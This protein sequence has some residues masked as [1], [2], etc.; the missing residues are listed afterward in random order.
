MIRGRDMGFRCNQRFHAVARIGRMAE[1]AQLGAQNNKMHNAHDFNNGLEDAATRHGVFHDTRSEFERYREGRDLPAK[2]TAQSVQAYTPPE[3]PVIEPYK[4]PAHAILDLAVALAPPV[5][6]IVAVG[7][8]LWVVVAACAAAV[9]AV[10]AFISAYALPIGGGLTALVFLVLAVF[11]A[12]AGSGGKTNN[13]M[14]PPPND[15][16]KYEWY[17]EQRQGWRKI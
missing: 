13:E 4:S 14:P 11:G 9:G 3:T 17:Q 1:K 7:G 2:K 15:G 5:V 12:K 6:G 8:V 16:G 10:T